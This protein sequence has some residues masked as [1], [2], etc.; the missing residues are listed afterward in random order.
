MTD[1]PPF[2]FFLG[3]RDLEMVEIA[4]L[5]RD[6]A[7]GAPLFDAGLAWGAKASDYADAIQ[8]AA[9]SGRRPVLVELALDLPLPD[10]ALVVD[11]HGDA[12]GAA[13]PT[14]LRQ[15]FALLGLPA[16]AWTR[17]MELV[18]ANDRGHIREMRSIGATAAE[19]AAIR[20]DD[21]AAQGVTADM[22]AAGERAVA[23]LE[24][25]LDG[26]A[27]LARL[28]H[29]RCAVVTDRL[30][31][32]EHRPLLV[33]SP[34]EINAYGPGAVIAALDRAFPGGWRG[35]ALPA[36]GFWGHAAPLP[37]EPAL[38]RAVA[39]GLGGA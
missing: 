33:L 10:G 18:A 26:R 32:D 20:R 23:A 3:G 13:A 36:Y 4:R 14:S 12:A 34:G 19:I 17:R 29:A 35:G 38:L 25:V 7:P 39:E 31:P 24:P 9:A 22:E 21:R 28:P 11:H 2:A 15:I 8:A 6:H 27:R 30:D 1:A 16:A 5:I 37:D